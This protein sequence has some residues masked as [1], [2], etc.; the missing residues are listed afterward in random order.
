[1][2]TKVFSGRADEEKLAFADS[3][4]KRE[5]GLSYGKYCGTVLLDS[6]D[7]S[8]K[9]PAIDTSPARLKRKKAAAAFIKGFSERKHDAAIGRMSDAEIRDLIARRYE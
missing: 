6:I 1:M 8:G 2:P 4:A 3:L 5:Y 9:L 7:N